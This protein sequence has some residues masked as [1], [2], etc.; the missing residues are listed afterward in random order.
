MADI[1]SRERWPNDD[2]SRPGFAK[3]YAMLQVLVDYIVK[4]DA[5]GSSGLRGVGAGADGAAAST[6][7]CDSG[8][9]GS[10]AQFIAGAV[11]HVYAANP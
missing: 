11:D 2:R 3:F 9:I 5:T 4:P 1:R 8:G 7:D 6:A 10:F